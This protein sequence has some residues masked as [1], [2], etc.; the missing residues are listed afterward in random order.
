VI[1][2]ALAGGRH[3]ILSAAATEQELRDVQV[4]GMVYFQSGTPECVH[5]WLPG[6]RCRAGDF[7][8]GVTLN[9]LGRNDSSIPLQM[10]TISR[11][12]RLRS[13]NLISHCPSD[14]WEKLVRCRQL[15]EITIGRGCL[16]DSDLAVL[17]RLPR[18]R[19]LDLTMG[20]LTGA[21]LR[22]VE[23]IRTLEEL[24]LNAMSG[25]FRIN[26]E[27]MQRDS[28][29]LKGKD[30]QPLAA[31]SLTK[32]NLAFNELGTSD[33]ELT[34]VGQMEHLRE[35]NIHNK[36]LTGQNVTA[37]QQLSSLEDLSLFD[38]DFDNPADGAR[39][40]SG[41]AKLRALSINRSIPPSTGR[42]ISELRGLEELCVFNSRS[43]DDDA[44]WI[45][46]IN[47]LRRLTHMGDKVS[48]SGIARLTKLP[49]LEALTLPSDGGK[50]DAIDS[51]VQMKALKT[52][53]CLL[54]SATGRARLEREHPDLKIAL[55]DSY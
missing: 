5:Q 30:L 13:L 14:S 54:I 28:Q 44:V 34:A 4:D 39:L 15:E 29:L 19:K 53:D 18:L 3:F 50:G 51:F 48:A 40:F 11:Q 17:A 46:Q 12:K 49:H 41:L 8:V 31:L 43:F 20:S 35:L 10:E 7:I 21:S 42:A 36:R 55:R 33:C 32:L 45:S 16:V 6:S 1:C 9:G 47:S 2:M 23:E 27:D 37:L 25:R 22:H 26:F 24:T 52:L 38:C